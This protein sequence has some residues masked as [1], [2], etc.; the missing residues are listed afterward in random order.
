MDNQFVCQTCGNI[1]AP[2]DTFCGHCGAKVGSGVQTIG[3]GK[4]IWIYFVSLFLP[5]LGLIWTWKYLRSGSPQQKRI[6]W[7]ALALTVVGILLTLWTIGGFLQGIQT[8]LN[9]YTNLGL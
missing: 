1:L 3:L 2:D 5:P 4:Q 8:Q 9:S 6:G 7:I